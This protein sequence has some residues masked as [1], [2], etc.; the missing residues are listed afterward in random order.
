MKGFMLSSVA[1]T[2]V[3][4]MLLLNGCGGSSGNS[5]EDQTNILGKPNVSIDEILKKVEK[6]SK[7]ITDV[8]KPVKVTFGSDDNKSS[9]G[10][11]TVT[12]SNV[13]GDCKKEDPCKVYVERY[14]DLNYENNASYVYENYVK[15]IV[16]TD[17]ND[18]LRYSGYVFVSG[19]NNLKGADLD[20]QLG[21]KCAVDP[22][23]GVKYYLMDDA[24][25]HASDDYRVKEAVVVVRYIDV[26]DGHKDKVAYYNAKVKY[27]NGKRILYD[28]RD[29]DDPTSKGI[30]S[31][32]LP[33]YAYVYIKQNKN[34]RDAYRVDHGITGAT[35]S[36][37]GVGG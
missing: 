17:E 20:L 7:S 12:V 11:S 14:C 35:G 34:Q 29:A 2:V 9:Q 6:G 28:L 36:T 22:E 27:E 19:S 31:A 23:T 24:E 37:G 18:T 16:P 15:G 1:A 25:S 10:S 5:G 33:A 3:A 4:S 8:K 32:R 21:L 26:T 30:K 13:Q